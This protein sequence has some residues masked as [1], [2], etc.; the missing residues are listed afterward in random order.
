M[1]CPDFVIAGAMRAATT[2]L[3]S[4]LGEHP[5]IFMA[6]PKEPNFFAAARGGLTFCGPGDQGFARTNIAEWNAYQR[7][8]RD[9]GSRMRGEASA[10][11]L[12]LPG[13]AADI[14][15]R[16]PET[17]IVIIMRD[18][19]ERAFSA[20]QYLRGQSREP[21]RDFRAALDAEEERR[22]R[23]YGPIWWYAQASRYDVALDEYLATFPRSQLHVLTTDELRR[24]PL[25]TMTAVCAFVGVD[26]TGFRS[27]S[28]DGAINRSGVPRLELLTRALHP[29]HRLREPLVR[30]A[31]PAV[32]ALVRRARAAS[33]VPGGQMPV[34]ARERLRGELAVVAP[35]VRRLTGLDTTSWQHR[36]VEA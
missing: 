29:H 23:G 4:A 21:M 9:A 6:T 15:R 17:K 2:A 22:S 18:P 31:P 12:S 14:R 35:E 8:F 33:V 25:G 36:G 13:V 27:S 10:A 5:E 30:I 20:W 16:S 24:D 1:A 34:E 19:V 11:Y 26:G 7:L 3:A 28:L 32:R